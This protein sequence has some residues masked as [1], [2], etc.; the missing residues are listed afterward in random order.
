VQAEQLNQSERCQNPMAGAAPG[1]LEKNDAVAMRVVQKIVHL[2]KNWK[3]VHMKL[4]EII[5]TGHTRL[6]VPSQS[7]DNQSA[8][9]RNLKKM[10]LWP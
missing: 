10:M 4:H 3:K 5:A 7:N 8:R 6:R 9:C 2:A 1:L